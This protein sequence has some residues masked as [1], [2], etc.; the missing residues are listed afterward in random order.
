MPVISLAQIV[1]SGTIA[2]AAGGAFLD[3]D[4]PAFQQRMRQRKDGY[5]GIEDFT[6]SRTTDATLLRFDARAIPGNEDYR[7]TARWEKFDAFY[8]EA[9]YKQFRTYYDGSGGRF[10]PRDLAISWFNEA[11]ELDRSYFSVEFGTLAPD[12]PQWRFRY[13]RMTRDGTKNSI[14]WGDS[15]LAGQPFVPRAFIPSYLL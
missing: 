11:L 2:F 14:R 4:E 8:V 13:D 10:L 6:W 3:G 5:G 12:R 1:T 7:F 9:N 15:N